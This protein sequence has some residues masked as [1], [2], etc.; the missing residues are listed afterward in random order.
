MR[1]LGQ[2]NLMAPEEFA[3]V[4]ERFEFLTGQL[5]DLTKARED[6]KKV[7]TEIRTESSEL[8]LDT[9]N[10]I[11]K[12]FHTMFRR[13]FGGGRAELRLEIPRT[14]SN[15]ASRSSRSPRARSSRT[16][17][18]SRAASDRS[19]ASRCCSPSTW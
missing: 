10:K 11:K 6:L 16:S 4:K 1:K 17:P 19:R 14:S 18:S 8:F 13:L 15:R 3:E 2:V 12:N 9:Y 5:A 7:T